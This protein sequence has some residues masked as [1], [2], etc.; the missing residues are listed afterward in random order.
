MVNTRREFF[1]FFSLEGVPRDLSVT[2]PQYGK[3]KR[4]SH[5]A[6]FLP[7]TAQKGE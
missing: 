2:I 7:I 6:F 4:S 3:R 5:S 1:F